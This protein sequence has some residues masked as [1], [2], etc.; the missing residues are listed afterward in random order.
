[1]KSRLPLAYQMLALQVCIV[2]VA[3]GVGLVLAAVQAAQELDRQYQQR[4]LAIAESV[5]SMPAI[6]SALLNQDPTGSIQPTA[7]EVR[8]TTGASYVVVADRRGIRFSHP[9]PGMI[10][11]PVDES[12]GPV[13]AGHTWVGVQR[14][15]LGVAARG[16]APIVAGG[17]VIGMVS[18]GYPETT[19]SAQLL[20]DMPGFVATVALALGLGVAG[21]LLLPRHV[22]RQ[23]FGLEPYEIAGLLEE[24]EASLQGIRE[25][26]V[27]TDADGRIT[28][29]NAEARRLLGLD[30]D[31]A[32]KRLPQVLPAGRLR[33][34]LAG[35]LRDEDEVLLAGDRV[36]LASRRPVQVRGR[37][38]GHVMT[39]RDSRELSSLSSGFGVD[40]LTDALRAQAHEFSNRLH[41][42]AGLV[43]L[44]RTEEAIGLITA[45]SGMHQELSEALM[46]RMGDPVLGALL[47]AKAAIAS[48]RGIELRVTEDTVLTES[49]LSPDDLITLLGNLVDNALEAV[50]QATGERWVSIAVS[51]QDEQLVIRVEDSGPGVPEADRERIFAEGYST[52]PRTT[53]RRRGIGLA[54]VRKVAR[55][56]GGDVAVAGGGAGAVFSARLPLRVVALG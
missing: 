21:S 16:K 14:G 36:L 37:E 26:A 5:A 32:G 22:K 35:R 41:T 38:V 6:R 29:V 3:A 33:D 17:E 45:T 44:G 54:L 23:T 53:G 13:L 4:S 31:C 24:R 7:E 28:L 15:T 49:P 8:R 20:N 34:F 12:P 48:E 50:A 40:S 39:L 56:H 11:R 43:E 47:L 10:G 9:N 25:G 51:A 55:R 18:V 42:I 19:V 46:E 2:V 27:A 52:R 1:M 30:A